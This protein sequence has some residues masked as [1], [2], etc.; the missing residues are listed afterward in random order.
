MEIE[1]STGDH[2]SLAD[3]LAVAFACAKAARAVAVAVILARR[4]AVPIGLQV[5]ARWPPEAQRS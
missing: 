2:G 3:A 1:G 5:C 4:V